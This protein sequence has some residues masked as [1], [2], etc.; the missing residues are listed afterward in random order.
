MRP[1]TEEET[2]TMFD[3][4]SKYIGADNIKLLVDRSDGTYCFRLQKER[5]YYVSEQIM[6][7]V[8][9]AVFI[10]YALFA[11]WPILLFGHLLFTNTLT[12]AIDNHKYFP[13]PSPQI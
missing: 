1:L 12:N 9:I 3:K 2:R 6:K 4:L 13:Y 7:Q 10:F 5:V 8:R 11:L